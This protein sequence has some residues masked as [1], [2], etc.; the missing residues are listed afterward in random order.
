MKRNRTGDAPKS[1]AE[2]MAELQ[3]DPAFVSRERER[4]R[5]QA[6][7]TAE[8]RRAASEL[9]NELSTMGLQVE[10]VGSLR[11]EGL[12]YRKAIPLLVSWLS[13]AS[14]PSVKEDIVRTLSVPSA[15]PIAARALVAEFERPNTPDALKWAVGNALEVVADDS[16]IADLLRLARDRQQGKARQ[17][18]VVA[19]GNAKMNGAVTEALI[20]LLCD[21]EVAVHAAIALGRLGD[22]TARPHLEAIA[23][24]S[25]GLLKKEAK[26]ALDKL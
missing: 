7:I 17:M 26:R 9:L 19:L 24:K 8:Y 6:D 12:D 14:N 15:R 1:A 5:K 25:K 11:D 21:D 20:E 13:R 10:S 23:K 22:V 4:A 2:L 3:R 18:V 16:V